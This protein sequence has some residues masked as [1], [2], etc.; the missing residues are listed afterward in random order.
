MVNEKLSDTR[1][2]RI[3]ELRIGNSA[4]VVKKTQKLR[5][6]SVIPEI[7]TRYLLNT[8]LKKASLL[9]SPARKVTRNNFIT[10]PLSPPVSVAI[11]FEP[12]YVTHS[13]SRK[14]NGFSGTPNVW[15]PF[16]RK[17]GGSHRTVV[18]ILH[19]T[20]WSRALLGKLTVAQL[21]K[22][23]PRFYATRKFITVLVNNLPVALFH[24]FIYS[25]HLSTCFEHQVLIIRRS[26][27]INT[28][29]GMISLCE[30]LL[31]MPP[32]YQVVT[33]TDKSY[34]MMY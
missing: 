23:F 28:S 15:F 29:S 9:Q 34:Q 3:S 7:R 1:T 22:V 27:C 19:L 20:Q 33:H 10:E 26:N 17:E 11:S 12:M 2:L 21:V 16:I 14:E 25:F 8:S 24:V 5:T 6:A 30:W 32:A 13:I 18:K 31:G 4:P